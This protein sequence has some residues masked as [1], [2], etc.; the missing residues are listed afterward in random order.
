MS[1]NNSK[2]HHLIPK[3]SMKK[4]VYEGNSVWGIN[5]L[6]GFGE[7]RNRDNFGGIHHYHTI[8]PGSYFVSDEQAKT[9]FSSLEGYT[10]FFTDEDER[11]GNSVSDPRELNSAYPTFN[12]W[13]IKHPSGKVVG[14]KA[15]NRLKK[16]IDSHKD[17]SIETGWDYQYEDKWNRVLDNIAN[18]LEKAASSDMPF[19]IVQFSDLGQLIMFMVSL[20][21]RTLPFPKEL[22]EIMDDRWSK[23]P[24]DGIDKKMVTIPKEERTFSYLET[25]Y[26]ERA[27][28][29]ILWLFK[30]FLNNQGPIYDEAQHVL[31]NFSAILYQA[32]EDKEFLTSDNPVCH[33]QDDNGK[34]NYYF[35]ITPKLA[36]KFGEKP[37]DGSIAQ[38]YVVS[39]ASEEELFSFN[40]RMKE[41]CHE[42]YIMKGDH[43]S[44][45]FGDNGAKE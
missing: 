9:F 16:E 35:P 27:H 2:Y 45:Y 19:H 40:K 37:K 13:I 42:V 33:Y 36:F 44:R 18:D 17:L 3:V 8:R 30:S 7:P 38:S 15:K 21:W 28:N 34:M 4:W 6:T 10:V 14:K 41:N 29:T 1:N 11:Q 24:E 5:Y 26:D 43:P 23:N 22:Q 31:E 25:V 32:P 39:Q 12:E 20:K